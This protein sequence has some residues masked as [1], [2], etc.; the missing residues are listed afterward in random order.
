MRTSNETYSL[1]LNRLRINETA[2]GERSR[3][4]EIAQSVSLLSNSFPELLIQH[5]LPKLSNEHLG[6]VIGD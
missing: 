6:L 1:W 4:H 3:E 5:L 2:A